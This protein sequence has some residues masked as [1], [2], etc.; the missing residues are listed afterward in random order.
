MCYYEQFFG[1]LVTEK[2]RSLGAK[3]VNKNGE[4]FIHPLEI[5]DVTVT[6]IIREC[7]E[8]IKT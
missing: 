6:S 8:K 2:V 5:R 1:A 7:S 4:V 3:L